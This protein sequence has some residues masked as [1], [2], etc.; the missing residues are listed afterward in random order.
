MVTTAKWVMPAI[1]VTLAAAQAHAGGT[2]QIAVTAHVIVH[3]RT[4]MLHPQSTC[5]AKTLRYLQSVR[6]ATAIVSTT[7]DD[8]SVSQTGGPQPK[9]GR[10]GNVV[11]VTF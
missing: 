9:I 5:T 4:T 10:K 8:V 2:A 3:C 1:S 11:V 7:N 6:N